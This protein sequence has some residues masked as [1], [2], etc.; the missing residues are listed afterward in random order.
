MKKQD[1]HK[2]GDEKHP[3]RIS[4]LPSWTVCPAMALF[5]WGQ[6]NNMSDDIIERSSWASSETGTAAG[7]AIELYHRRGE[8]GPEAMKEIVAEVEAQKERGFEDRGAGKSMARAD[9]ELISKALDR[10]S[11]DARNHGIVLPEFMEMEVEFSM[12]CPIGGEV[13]FVGHVDAIVQRPDGGLEINDFKCSKFTLDELVAKHALQLAGYAMGASKKL[14]K[15]VGVGSIVSIRSYLTKPALKKPPEQA[16]THKR[17][18]WRQADCEAALR[19]VVAN[20]AR[21]RAGSVIFGIGSHCGYCPAS[22]PPGVE[23]RYP[24]NGFANCRSKFGV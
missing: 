12:P 16:A 7:I 6:E 5:S 4:S 18:G 23:P 19:T 3:I 9:F 15:R 17:L 24:T 13:F 20:V 11:R 14:G 22:L 10:Y 21:A 8:A 2:I 1:W